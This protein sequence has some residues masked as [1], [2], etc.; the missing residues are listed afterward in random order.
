[1]SHTFP[2]KNNRAWLKGVHKSRSQ[3]SFLLGK[4]AIDLLVKQNL[5]ITLKTISEKSKEIDS[6]GKGIHSNTIM[7]N[8]ELNEYY[9]QNSKTYKQKLNSNKSLQKRSVPFTPVDYRR[10]RSD[11]NIENTERK[12]MKMSKKELVQRLILAEKYI[13]ENNKMWAG[14]QFEQFQ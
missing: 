13:A 6:E 3:R 11:R 9:K 4:E 1:M 5:P 12:Y 14:K 10:I 2:S 7:I 8:P